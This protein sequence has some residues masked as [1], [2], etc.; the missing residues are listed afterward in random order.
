MYF[1]ILF[2]IPSRTC[3]LQ[4][5][6]GRLYNQNQTDILEIV[7]VFGSKSENHG[8]IK[9]PVDPQNH[10]PALMI[11]SLAS[12]DINLTMKNPL[13]QRCISHSMVHWVKIQW[14]R[15]I[16]FGQ[17]QLNWQIKAWFSY[18][19]T[20]SSIPEE[21]I[22]R[23]GVCPRWSTIYGLGVYPPWSGGDPVALLPCKIFL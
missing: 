13:E 19:L 12:G 21:S 3:S 2:P 10:G 4:K 17:K 23:A 6:R 20:Y 11:L 8:L 18:S 9:R 22:F 5:W 7:M 1:P 14:K 15:S 16:G